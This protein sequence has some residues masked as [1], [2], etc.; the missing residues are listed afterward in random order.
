MSD[1]IEVFKAG[2]HIDSSGK[3]HTYSDEDIENI[4]NKYNSQKE[5]QAPAVLGHPKD[6]DPAYAWA[7]EAK[8]EKGKL[9]V[10]FKDAFDGFKKMVNDGMFKNRSISLYPDGL[11]RHIGFLGA[12]PPA[13]KGMAAAHFSDDDE[14]L[15]FMD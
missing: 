11:I 9:L 4:A 6:N 8:A 15:E 2:K 7:E 5:H 12:V 13:V 14:Y 10:K 1:W 3:E